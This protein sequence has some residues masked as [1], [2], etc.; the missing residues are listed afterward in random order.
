MGLNELH[1]DQQHFLPPTDSRFRPDVRHLENAE[2]GPAEDCKKQLEQVSA[3]GDICRPANTRCPNCRI[4]AIARL[5]PINVCGSKRSWTRSVG[6]TC[7]SATDA[8]GLR[9][10][11][12][13][14]IRTVTT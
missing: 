11:P 8:I 1:A 10:V 9:N 12:T 4:N 5:K 13:S 6:I 3:A 14:K 7:G 2:V